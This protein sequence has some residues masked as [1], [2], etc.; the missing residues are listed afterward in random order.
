MAG[1]KGRSGGA[2]PNSGGPRKGAGRSQGSRNR[3]TLIEGLPVT[4][5]PLVWLLGLVNSDHAPLRVRVRA[6]VVLL[7]YL[8]DME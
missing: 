7:P 3:P 2:R 5:D 4:A 8:P 6:A 1:V